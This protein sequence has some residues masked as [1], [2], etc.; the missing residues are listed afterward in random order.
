MKAELGDCL[1]CI[2]FPSMEIPELVSSCEKYPGLIESNVYNDLLQ[3]I[4]AG[5]RLTAAAMFSTESRDAACLPAELHVFKV[6]ASTLTGRGLI[7]PW[8]PEHKTEC[9][10]TLTLRSSRALRQKY[11][12]TLSVLAPNGKNSPFNITL[13]SGKKANAVV[14]Y[15]HIEPDV[16]M[17]A[18][19]TN[20]IQKLKLAQIIEL[21]PEVDAHLVLSCGTVQLPNSWGRI[22][23]YMSRTSDSVSIDGEGDLL[24]EEVWLIEV[25]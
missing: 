24:I 4:S 2:R 12:V 8:L 18:S 25:D 6:E 20:C 11:L 14:V 19:A 15:A 5:R 21:L 3:H 13:S 9:K 17:S 10:T 23:Q 16:R 22:R 7:D 1:N